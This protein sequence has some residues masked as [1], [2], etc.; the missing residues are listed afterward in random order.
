MMAPDILLFVNFI[1]T[2][3]HTFLLNGERLDVE[4]ISKVPIFA[5]IIF[6]V[7]KQP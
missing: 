2:V 6:Y 3:L 1:S 4:T 7:Q 5:C